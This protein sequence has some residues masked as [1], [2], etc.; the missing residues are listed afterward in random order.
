MIF[1]LTFKE[2][3]PQHDLEASI[4]DT[5]IV[6]E[7]HVIPCRGPYPHVEP[8]KNTIQFTPAQVFFL[9]CVSSVKCWFIVKFDVSIY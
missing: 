1:R 6:V 2:L 7:P 9:D 3:E 5:S 4:R 8:R